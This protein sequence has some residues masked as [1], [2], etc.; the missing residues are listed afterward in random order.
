MREH[1]KH[2]TTL[3]QL[4]RSTA[5]SIEPTEVLDPDRLRN[6]ETRHVAERTRRPGILV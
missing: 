2:L 3:D 6:L 4:A 5:L 1:T